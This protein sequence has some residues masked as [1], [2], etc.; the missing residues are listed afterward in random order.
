[1]DKKDRKSMELNQCGLIERIIMALCLEDTSGKDTPAEK[2]GLHK[3]ELGDLNQETWNYRSVV[4][5]MMM[6]LATNSRPD[7]AFAV[8]QVARFSNDPKG[9]HERAVK[10]IGRYLKATKNRGMI[11]VPDKVLGL[12]LFTDVDFAGLY[13]VEDVNKSIS[14]ESRTGWLITFLLMFQSHGVPSCN[15]K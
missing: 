15:Q 10:R 2:R 6:Y 14:V 13:N 5:V 8:N 7:I 3:N 9:I 12:D 11:I 1:M 4:G